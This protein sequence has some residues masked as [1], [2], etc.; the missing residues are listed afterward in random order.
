MP[1]QS[2]F[3]R[4]IRE[5]LRC[6]QAMASREVEVLIFDG[7]EVSISSP[8]EVLFPETDY[9]KL[10]LVKYYLA[11]APGALRGAGGRPNVLVRYVNG[12]GGEFFYPKRAPETGC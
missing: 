3:V 1:T 7:H 12:I 6:L 4:Q 8:R 9:T 10:D 2:G 5:V 11:V